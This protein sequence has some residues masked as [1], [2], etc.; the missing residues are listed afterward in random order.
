MSEQTPEPAIRLTLDNGKSFT[1][2]E[3]A[4]GLEWL[5]SKKTATWADMVLVIHAPGF[6]ATKNKGNGR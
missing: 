3:I 2:D 5:Y 1:L 6:H 4:T